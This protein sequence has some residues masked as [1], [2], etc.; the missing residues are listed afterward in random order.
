M[1]E[2]RVLVVDDDSGV[3][4]L[5]DHV[6]TGAGYQCEVIDNLGEARDALERDRFALALIDV[7]V[8]SESGADLAADIQRHHEDTA[9]LMISGIDDPDIANTTLDIGAYGYITKPFTPNQ[10]LIDVSGALRRRSLETRFREH[11]DALERAVADRTAELERSVTQEKRTEAALR[12]RELLYQLVVEASFDLIALHYTDGR[13]L[14]VSPSVERILGHTPEELIGASSLDL[15]H[16][17]DAARHVRNFTTLR[18]G[19]R[20]TIEEVRLRHRDGRW[21][22]CETAVTWDPS[23]DVVLTV[24]R[25]VTDRLRFEE[26]L[27]LHN[28]AIEATSNGIVICDA[29]ATD[30]PVVYVNPAFEHLT[31]YPSDAV[32]GRNCRFL[33]GP[34][35]DPA[36]KSEMRRALAAE[37]ETRQ[38][39]LNYRAD[40]S[41]FWNQLTISPARD[42]QGRVSHYIGVLNDITA[43]REAEDEITFLA[44]HDVLTRLPNRSLFIEHL[45]VAMARARRTGQAVAVALLD[46]NNFKLVN[47]TLGHAAGDELLKSFA[48]RLLS[49]TRETDVLARV[50]G[51][52]FLMLLPDLPAQADAPGGED[53]ME[54]AQGVISKIRHVLEAPFAV[55]GREVYIDLSLGLSLYPTTAEDRDELLRQADT[56]MYQTKPNSHRL[57][58]GEPQI[59]DHRDQLALATRLHKAI[60]QDELLLHYQPIFDLHTGSPVAVEALLRWVDARHGLILPADFIPLAE[61]MG[62]MERITE[63]VLRAVCRQ[64]REW[65]NGSRIPISFNVPPAMWRPEMVSDV[66]EARRAAGIGPEGLLMEVTESTVMSRSAGVDMEFAL[67]DQR[68]KIMI[69]DFGVGYSSLGRLLELPVD[70]LKIDRSFIARIGADGRAERIVTTML[71]LS[72]SLGIRSLA[73]GIETEDQRQFLIDHGCELGQGYLLGRPLP[74]DQVAGLWKE[75]VG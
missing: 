42:G 48:H 33:Q 59:L 45:D 22:V 49:V 15:V 75:H 11:E 43:R 72:E 35:T 55:S 68:V 74:P 58:V 57:L 67:V 62:L 44:Y 64:S 40:G 54:I 60:D 63:W 14:Y 41:T 28:R 31:G 12:R 50:G 65:N 51:D 53:A 27:R 9:V 30:L 32:V 13:L 39:L 1:P 16:P 8:G 24:C 37:R 2:R 70:T 4:T 71:Q 73:E 69:D 19:E 20:V 52:E 29:L 21:V 3:G 38:V 18:P 6:L 66:V 47:D 5:L 17:E 61:R 26:L 10:L 36:A 23:E 56:A 46:L 7:Q 34:D 25:D